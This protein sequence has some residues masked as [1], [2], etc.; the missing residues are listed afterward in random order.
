[1]SGT[2]LKDKEQT[3]YVQL[4]I[5]REKCLTGA[6]SR[7]DQNK[8]MTNE[9]LENFQILMI[10]KI[11]LE[12]IYYHANVFKIVSSLIF[13]I[14]FPFFYFLS[15]VVKHPVALRTRLFLNQSAHEY[16]VFK[17]RWKHLK[18]LQSRTLF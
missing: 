13:F 5:K 9:K 6:K 14:L 18:S 11:K 17:R 10:N 2:F 1:M 15:A 12:I 4:A 8:D 7:S 16:R 3:I